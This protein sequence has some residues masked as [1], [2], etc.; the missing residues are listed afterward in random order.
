M[1]DNT[2]NKIM[3]VGGVNT[4]TNKAIIE[5]VELL[6]DNNF[7][8]VVIQQP[9]QIFKFEGKEVAQR[10]SVM[11]ELSFTK[12]LSRAERRKLKRNKK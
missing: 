1:K 6:K 5:A 9:E 2:M 7:E 12:P 10:L 11:N 4:A 3:I 8:V